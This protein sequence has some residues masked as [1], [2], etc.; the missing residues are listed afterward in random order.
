[1]LHN[2]R[3]RRTRSLRLV[4]AGGQLST[5]TKTFLESDPGSRPV[6]H[7]EL[8]GGLEAV[9]R[10]LQHP[11]GLLNPALAPSARGLHSVEAV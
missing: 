8:S 10:F 1:M 7:S 9:A 6:H 5:L 11:S 3:C 4:L 2:R